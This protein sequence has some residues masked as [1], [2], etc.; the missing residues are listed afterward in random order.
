M[1]SVQSEKGESLGTTGIPGGLVSEQV[2]LWSNGGGWSKRKKCQV[3]KVRLEK[4][5]VRGCLEDESEYWLRSW[6]T[7]MKSS[8]RKQK[9]VNKK[10]LMKCLVVVSRV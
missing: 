2:G 5:H 1:S 6:G 7:M 10:K 3:S 4:L 8:S 9:V